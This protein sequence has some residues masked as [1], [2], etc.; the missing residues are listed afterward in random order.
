MLSVPI[1]DIGAAYT[2]EARGVYGLVSI[3]HGTAI[4][5]GIHL[6]E[7]VEQGIE[8][9]RAEEPLEEATHVVTAP[10]IETL[11]I[12]QGVYAPARQGQKLRSNI[13]SR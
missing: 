13:S 5:R 7:F 1:V 4:A 9:V 6:G 10:H 11:V 3:A 8:V 2:L 12:A